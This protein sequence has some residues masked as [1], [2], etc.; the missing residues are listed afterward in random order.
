MSSLILREQLT[1]VGGSTIYVR[2]GYCWKFQ[3]PLLL[4][5]V[6]PND[7]NHYQPSSKDDASGQSNSERY[8]GN[9]ATYSNFFTSG[10]TYEKQVSA[11]I[12]TP[13]CHH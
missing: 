7:H 2:P 4:S 11:H 12:V 1:V 10:R 8:D 9:G 3:T 6:I 5:R 13:V